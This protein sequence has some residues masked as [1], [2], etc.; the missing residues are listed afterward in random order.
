MGNIDLGKDVFAAS[1]T[2]AQSWDSVSVGAKLALAAD[3]EFRRGI[4]IDLG[5]SLLA[6]LDASIRKFIAA[7]LQGQLQAQASV[8]GQIQLP[9]N[10]FDEAGF[11]VRLQAVAE[12]AAGIRAKLGLT[13]GDFLD[14]A[15]SDPNMR[16]TPLKLLRVF[17]EHVD[18]QASFFA[19]AAVTAQAYA[20]VVA[21]GSLVKNSR[22]EGPGFVISGGA[23]AGLK[24]GAGYQISASLAITDVSQLI[25]QTVD[26]LVDDVT[27]QLLAALPAN[28]PL[29][30]P[31]RGARVPFKMAL[32]LAFELGDHLARA[33]PP[34]TGS[35]QDALSLS[36][37]QVTLE[38]LQRG[39]VEGFLDAALQEVQKIITTASRTATAEWTACRP[40]RLAFAAFLR[41]GP[42]FA[43][44]ADAIPFWLEA[45]DHIAAL[46]AK[47][48]A[49]RSALRSHAATIWCA[50]K[51]LE[52]IHARIL[53][54][55]RTKR[56]LQ[57]RR[58]VSAFVGTLPHGPAPEIL[59]AI[60]QRVPSAGSPLRYE[61]LIEYLLD[62]ASVQTLIQNNVPVISVLQPLVGA[63]APAIPA[64]LDLVLRN[65]GSLPSA[66]GAAMDPAASL[67]AIIG[68]LSQFA[69][70][71]LG[72]AFRQSLAPAFE[73]R[74]ELRLMFD[75]VVLPSLDF[76]LEVAS[77]TVVRWGTS[78]MP[79]KVLTEGL[80]A[81]LLRIL[82]RSLVL[83]G[84]ILM[85]EAQRSMATVMRAV[86]ADARKPGGL[87][88]TLS[89]MPGIGLAA[90]DIAE[91]VADALEIAADIFG[92]LPADKRQRIRGLMYQLID[93]LGGKPPAQLFE[94]LSDPGLPDP[95]AMNAFAHELGD[96][97]I[98][99]FTLFVER[100][101]H[102]LLE[103]MADAF[104]EALDQAAVA[105]VAWAGEVQHGIAL[106]VA[107][108]Q[109]LVADIAVAVA[110]GERRAEQALESFHDVVDSF[111]SPTALDRFISHVVDKGYS[112]AL[113]V[114]EDDQLYRDLVP[115]NL[116][117]AIRNSIHSILRAALE[118]S[119]LDE[120]LDLF[121]TITDEIDDL[122]DDCRDLPPGPGFAADVRELVLDR[123]LA[124]VDDGFRD[125][126]V[127]VSVPV[128]IPF[129]GRRTINLGNVRISLNAF[130]GAVRT[131]FQGVSVFDN[132]INAFAEQV[133]DMLEA[134]R[135]ARTAATEKQQVSSHVDRMRDSLD[136]LSTDDARVVIEK[137]ASM[138]SVTDGSPLMIR[139][140]GFKPGILATADDAPQRVYV[141]L[142]GEPLDLGSFRV[143]TG[144]PAQSGNGRARAAAGPTIVVRKQGTPRSR[145]KGKG[146]ALQ[147]GS[148]VKRADRPATN[149][150]RQ[151]DDG[152]VLLSGHLP[153]SLTKPGLNH[154]LVDVIVDASRRYRASIG[155][156]VAAA[157]PPPVAP[158]K[159][160][161]GRPAMPKLPTA[162]VPKVTELGL[163]TSSSRKAAAD[164][165][166]K[167]AG[168]KPQRPA[169]GALAEA[170]PKLATRLS[171]PVTTTVTLR[172]PVRLLKP[173]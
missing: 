157:A 105:V 31:V 167:A 68:G 86:A 46:A 26:L 117:S 110:E 79:Q 72:S 171:L 91:L 95:D 16:G 58:I 40:Q 119:P 92:P 67:Q 70:N 166:G 15:A 118:A 25:G 61:N 10:L 134:E 36:A 69:T 13:F 9:M 150:P 143:S 51:L 76:A 5:L 136:V 23:G 145:A 60:Q 154:L 158:D 53:Q 127:H 140:V 43:F 80:S 120:V 164:Q 48:S 113:A 77:Q 88:A 33:S 7:D 139:L 6:N 148:V 135:Q 159:P 8:R 124:I 115:S 18:L 123:L 50:V 152:F 122:V 21:T 99:R 59:T 74:P 44:S 128:D 100:I 137:P 54:A 49:P 151:D 102:K 96:Y 12:L 47:L 107:R 27:E 114:L 84:D 144:L 85:Y 125:V 45:I 34:H 130:T 98:D 66:S 108:V 3:I 173:H 64:V 112:T 56:D 17:L 29:Q 156:H 24:A 1:A 30:T 93:P 37:L 103:H 163:L 81:I 121:R 133:K 57:P 35:G 14:L 22:G 82:G 28:S 62:A 161:R 41:N 42:E 65:A 149:L 126:S 153:A 132:A 19:K 142:N 90:D 39:A 155:F 106:A 87:V 111:S 2:Q 97:A 165:L 101:V 78:S 146:A 94:A 138:Q 147:F 11:A 129:I 168:K 63:V 73:T 75:D 32:R 109:E 20:N 4:D 172:N 116:K 55:D 162:R 160:G 38:E 71:Q 104:H 170:S 89:A 83:T 141:V 131:M 169:L 52:S